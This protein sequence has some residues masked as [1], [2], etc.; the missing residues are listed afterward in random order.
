MRHIIAEMKG[1][2]HYGWDDKYKTIGDIAKEKGDKE[3][4]LKQEYEARKDSYYASF[5]KK[6]FD[7]IWLT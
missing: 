2:N 5:A 1:Q 6:V 3:A 4:K 7:Y